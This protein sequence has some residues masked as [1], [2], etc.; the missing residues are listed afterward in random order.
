MKDPLECSQL[1]DW[2]PIR[3][4]VFRVL[5][6]HLSTPRSRKSGLPKPVALSIVTSAL[7]KEGVPGFRA[8]G[9]LG[10]ISSL[11]RVFDLDAHT[12]PQIPDLFWMR[13]K[14][15]ILPALLELKAHFVFDLSRLTVNSPINKLCHAKAQHFKALETYLLQKF[16][17]LGDIPN[18]AQTVLNL[19]LDPNLGF[20]K[21][22]ARGGMA[23]LKPAPALLLP[24]MLAWLRECYSGDPWM[25]IR[26]QGRWRTWTRFDAQFSTIVSAAES[27]GYIKC[28]SISKAP[29]V[30][31][32]PDRVWQ[33]AYRHR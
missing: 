11:W 15:P 6:Q 28:V 19:A 17:E 16:P 3:L 5:L 8:S 30:Q 29:G 32:M 4:F 12:T 9:V 13:G 23:F 26:F 7:H 20:L 21:A 33:E 22:T 31:Y 10:V 27:E 14:I 1:G 2:D 18:G 25:T 24:E